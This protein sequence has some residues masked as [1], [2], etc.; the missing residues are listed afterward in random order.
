MIADFPLSETLALFSML[1]AA[2]LTAILSGWLLI[3]WIT[4]NPPAARPSTA[5]LMAR[6]RREWMA[7]MVDRSPRLFDAQALA[8]LRQGTSFFASA[9]MIATG[10]A[11]ALIGNADRLQGLALDLTLGDDPRILW[12]IK[13]LLAVFFLAN[14]FLKF[15]WS[16]RL[17]GY[18]LVLMASVPNDASDP[19]ALPRAAQAAEVNITAT[20]A[21]NR[22]LRAIYF[23]MA[24]LAWML[25]P[26]ALMAATALTLGMLW[27]REFASQ[28]RAVLL[29][30]DLP[31][32][33]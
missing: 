7:V 29:R 6:Y 19:R 8:T 25:G 28:S 2:A 10:G 3:G 30:G 26:L 11:L 9:S 33:P 17:F 21:Y 15:V 18:C 23:A 22:G 16:H 31:P 13:L 12:E 1:D 24:A 27:R 14:A 4:E 32:Q 20:R 5:T